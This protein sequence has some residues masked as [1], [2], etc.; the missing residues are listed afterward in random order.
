MTPPLAGGRRVPFLS[1][2]NFSF[3]LSDLFLFV[4]PF[5]FPGFASSLFFFLP[6]RDLNMA[7]PLKSLLFLVFIPTSPFCF[8][9]LGEFCIVFLSIMVANSQSSFFLPMIVRV[10]LLLVL[11]FCFPLCPPYSFTG[12]ALFRKFSDPGLCSSYK[13]PSSFP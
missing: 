8:D 12:F 6:L 7:R 3:L 10:G 4:I 2:P 13:P 9:G 5:Y 11:R 1:Q